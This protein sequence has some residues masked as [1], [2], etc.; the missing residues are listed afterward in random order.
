MIWSPPWFSWIELNTNGLSKG[1]SS[2]TA[3]GG[4]FKDCY[5]Q[6]VGGF[7]QW[8]D[9]RNSFFFVEFSAII[10]GVEFAY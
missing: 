8:I 6:F 3:Y 5:S 10:I 9:H 4:V 7:C 1:N 2:L